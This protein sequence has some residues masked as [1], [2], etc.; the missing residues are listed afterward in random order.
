MMVVPSGVIVLFLVSHWFSWLP[1]PELWADYV[2]ILLCPGCGLM[3][4][5]WSVCLLPVCGVRLLRGLLASCLYVVIMY[6]A[7][8]PFLMF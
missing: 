2:L 5:L 6:R 1:M 4:F 7:D 3:F 8:V